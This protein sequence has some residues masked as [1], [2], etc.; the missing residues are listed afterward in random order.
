[1][2]YN[3]DYTFVQLDSCSRSSSRSDADILALFSLC[4]SGCAI[5]FVVLSQKSSETRIIAAQR[6]ST[7]LLGPM[8]SWFLFCLVFQQA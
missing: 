1:M 6:N 4:V 2:F 5:A 7:T 8:T 3:N